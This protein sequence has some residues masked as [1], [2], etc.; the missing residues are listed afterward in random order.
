ML[1]A[2]AVREPGATASTQRA[3]RPADGGRSR[4][5]VV[6]SHARGGLGEVLVADDTELNR[7]VAL[8]EILPS[9]ADD[10]QSRARFVLEAEVTGRLEHPG[11]VPV[12]GLGFYADGRPYYAM[13]F[14]RGDS[15]RDAIKAHHEGS[16]A[17]D[18]STRSLALRGL[19]RR[20]V[21]VCN[22]VAYAHSRGVLHRDLKPGNVMLGPYGETLVVDWGLAKVVGRPDIL[23]SG[24]EVEATLRPSAGSGVTPTLQGSAHGTPAYMSPEQAAGLVDALGPASDVY[25][26][27]VVLYAVLTGQGPFED[28]DVETVLWKVM[29]GE[30]PRPREV[31]P[32]ADR[33][34]EAVCLKA[35]ALRPEDRH[36][37][38]RDLADDVERWLADEPVS[39]WREPI[40]RRVGRWTRRHRTAVVASAAA[41]L[42]A[43]AGLSAVLVV[44]DLDNERLRV[45]YA[46]E[47]L[48]NIALVAANERERARFDLALEAIRTFHSGVSRDV[49]L[50]RAEFTAL[51][52]ELLAGARTFY[53]KMVRLLQGQTDRRSKEALADAYTEVGQL[54]GAIGSKRDALAAYELARALRESL[55]ESPSD[56]DALAGTL[57]NIGILLRDTGRP[58][59]ALATFN[60]SLRI[61]E[62]LAAARPSEPSYRE[63][64]GRFLNNVG[65]LH[66]TAGRYDAA[67]TALERSRSIREALVAGRPDSAP[68]RN[69]LAVSLI[70]LGG[71]Y[72]QAGRTA[73]AREAWV[74]ARD[75]FESLVREAPDN[76][77]YRNMLA[78]VLNNAADVDRSTGHPLE[79]LAAWGRARDLF[80][81]LARDFPTDTGYRV[82]LAGCKLNR[83]VLLAEMDRRSEAL[84]AYD[85]ARGDYEALAR[86]DPSAPGYRQDLA[87]CLNNRGALSQELGRHVEARV[88][89][90]RALAIRSD[91]VR[92][93]PTS[94]SYRNDLAVT[95][96]GLGKTLDSSGR[97]DEALEA[98]RSAGD[99]W[100]DLLRE[101]P[102]VPE[103]RDRLAQSHNNASQVHD[104]AGRTA[105]AVAAETRARDLWEKLTDDQPT[106]PT[107]RD[108]LVSCQERLSRLLLKAGRPEEAVAGLERV[109]RSLAAD[110]STRRDDA[111]A[112]L[113][114]A[115]ALRQLGATR[116]LA[117]RPTDAAAAYRRCVS[118]RESLP[119][120][121]PDALVDQARAHTRLGALAADAAQAGVAFDLALCDLRKAAQDGFRHLEEVAHGP[122]FAPLRAG[123]GFSLLMLDLAMP[124]D[125]FAPTP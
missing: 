108:R 109:C 122:D 78:V 101:Q 81:S 116:E 117:G 89:F 59:E 60:E 43:L 51:R 34:L 88:A 37:S 38:A 8:K 49:L 114:L 55:A 68:Y 97:T 11:V 1:R 18:P 86:D 84:A 96:N 102:G 26:L 125:P 72:L 15:L 12:Y 46:R 33:A 13:R 66:R 30:F 47:R 110:A 99:M 120:L 9:H 24:A 27:G 70:N 92:S 95:T 20:F 98:F 113:R 42:M 124:T 82:R 41:G 53:D 17:R 87:L 104:A 35:M 106:V 50:K 29:R 52:G 67:R 3:R 16:T 61:E 121:P 56:R 83:G 6:R 4:Y 31:N 112:I 39:A 64:L 90:E 79:A 85:E 69:D 94:V 10:P 93:Q 19:L 65:L 44:K 2:G 48:A 14:I 119:E 118:V 73:D 80:Q 54:V 40:P 25:S 111:D 28:R 36:A 76:A 75:V 123:P 77:G 71:L 63:R 62:E 57:N 21:D 45:A 32:R 58:D 74:R 100:E 22:A 105:E 91:L 5:H 107:Y 23:P 115:A 7:Q 103:F